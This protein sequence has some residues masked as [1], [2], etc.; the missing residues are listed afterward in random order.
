M[1]SNNNM[2]PETIM[3]VMVL[4]LVI[5]ILQVIAWILFLGAVAITSYMTVVA[6]MCWK[7][8]RIIHGEL[9]TP[10]E[11]QGFIIRG[12]IGGF[13]A[14]FGAELYSIFAKTHFSENVTAFIV[15]AGYAFGSVV[16]GIAI[17]EEQ[18]KARELTEQSQKQ[19]ILP[20]APPPMPEQRSFHFASWDDEER[21]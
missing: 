20:P 10:E 18:K 17:K 7:T 14:F 9:V 11:A 4:A 19:E 1:S 15:F 8:P 13:V 16:I 2:S 12:I 5:L 6:L 3:F 21:P